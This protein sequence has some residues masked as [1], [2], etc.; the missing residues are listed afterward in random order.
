MKSLLFRRRQS[1]QPPATK[2]RKYPKGTP[3][4]AKPFLEMSN[5]KHFHRLVYIALRARLFTDFTQTPNVS[6]TS[7]FSCNDTSAK[8]YRSIGRYPRRVNIVSQ[9]AISGNLSS[10]LRKRTLLFRYLV[11]INLIFGAW[12]LYWRGTASINFQALWISIPLF[13]AE[14]YSYCGGILFLIGLWRPLVRRVK[15]LKQMYPSI[16]E[17]LLPTVDIFIACYNEPVDLVEKTAKAALQIDYPAT[18]LAVYILDD[19]ASPE[20]QAMADNL[21][22]LDLQS[23]QMQAAAT[24]LQQERLALITQLEQLQ[25]LT[26][27]IIESASVLESFQLQ[28]SSKND[29]LDK[30]LNWFETLKR[31]SIPERTWLEVVTAL[32][33]LFD[34]VLEHA[35]QDL[36]PETPITLEVSLLSQAIQIKIFD[37]GPEFDLEYY[38]DNQSHE[39]DSEAEGGRGLLIV[40]QV[41]DYYSY[42]RTANYGNCFTLIKNY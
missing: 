15:S 35:H 28:V 9:S 22:L 36:P 40:Q 16:P 20:M 38:L 37:C 27:D 13:L 24:Q 11:I 42:T 8:R 30:V 32:G 25:A 34:N 4:M 7:K 29:E 31:D 19:G 5:S 39:V 17:E 21:G 23:P 14:L 2:Y 10:R 3:E 33:E 26:P 12:Y 6:K 41:A 1:K 18:K